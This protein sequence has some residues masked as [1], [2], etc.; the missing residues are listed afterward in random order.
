MN[1]R[2]LKKTS[3]IKVIKKAF[4]DGADVTEDIHKYRLSICSDCEYNSDNTPTNDLNFFNKIRKLSYPS[5]SFCISCGCYLKEKTGQSLEQCPMSPPKWFKSAI[6]VEKDT[7]FNLINLSFEK[8]NLDIVDSEYLVLVGDVNTLKPYSFSLEIDFKDKK[9]SDVK[10]IPSCSLCTDFKISKT[11]GTSLIVD[12]T[13]HSLPIGAI[14]KRLTVYYKINKEQY[15]STIR[16][17]GTG[18]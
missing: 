17:N 1:T 7:D 11:K 16:I 2:N 4:F 13:I 10:I 9:V 15:K 12:I 6:T 5:K 3:K 18:I 8:V 14:N